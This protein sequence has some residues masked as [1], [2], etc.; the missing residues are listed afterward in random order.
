[1]VDFEDVFTHPG[2]WVLM[3]VVLVIGGFIGI[4]IGSNRYYDK[5]R[6]LE[7]QVKVL[8]D[9]VK[10]NPYRQM[11]GYD[12]FFGTLKPYNYISVDYGETWYAERVKDTKGGWG[13]WRHNGII[14]DANQDHI[15]YL[16]ARKEAVKELKESL[17][18]EIDA[19]KL[20]AN[21]ET[22]VASHRKY[23]SEPGPGKLPIPDEALTP[24]LTAAG[25]VQPD[26]E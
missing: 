16:L 5:S 19:D 17:G 26:P 6:K 2:T 25:N 3:V 12:R 4:G 7:K 21:V 20:L 18:E 11:S 8:E 24:E 1:M 14:G 13:R 15:D 22:L 10:G 23:G 9:K